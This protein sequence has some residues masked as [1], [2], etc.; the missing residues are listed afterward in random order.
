MGTKGGTTIDTDRKGWRG[1]RRRKGLA[2]TW[3]LR[4]V[5]CNWSETGR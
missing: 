5:D 1:G 4:C 3:T 2:M